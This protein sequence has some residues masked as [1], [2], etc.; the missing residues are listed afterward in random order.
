MATVPGGGFATA[1]HPSIAV[2][3]KLA[4]MATAG[5]IAESPCRRSVRIDATSTDALVLA[6]STSAKPKRSWLR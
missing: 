5:K 4:D 6:V 2:E 1:R 3:H